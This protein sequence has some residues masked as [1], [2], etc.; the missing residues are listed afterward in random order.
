[1]PKIAEKDKNKD[2]NISPI[3]QKVES[4]VGMTKKNQKVNIK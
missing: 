2:D 1:V 3:G 4:Q